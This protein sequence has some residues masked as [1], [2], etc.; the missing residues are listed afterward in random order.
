MRNVSD[1]ICRENQNKVLYSMTFLKNR[2]V[3]E[4]MW[5]NTVHPGRPQMTIWRMRIACWIPKNT[6]T[7]KNSQYAIFTA[8][9]LQKRLHESVSVLRHTYI[10]PLVN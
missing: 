3:C 1:K 4:M 9:P 2:A 5:K 10:S 6:D 7:D 8:W